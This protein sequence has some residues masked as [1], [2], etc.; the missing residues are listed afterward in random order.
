MNL[1]KVCFLGVV[2]CTT[3][4]AAAQDVADEIL[5]EKSTVTGALILR[6]RDELV[7]GPGAEKTA[8]TTGHVAEELDP[9]LEALL[10]EAATLEK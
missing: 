3:G 5:A 4:L 10:E 1:T 2:L 8:E 9:E 6:M 7:L